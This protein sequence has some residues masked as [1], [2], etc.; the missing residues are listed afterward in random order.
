MNQLITLRCG[1]RSELSGLALLRESMKLSARAMLHRRQTGRWLEL[2]NSHPLFRQMLPACPRLVNK[3]YRSYF[4]TRLGCDDRLA[5]LQAHYQTVIQRG[6]APLVARAAE[7]PVEL[8]RLD[9]KTGQEY[10]IELRAG[11]VLCREGELILQLAHGDQV[12]YSIAF[13]FLHHFGAVAVGVGCLQGKH[14]GGGLDQ[15][16]D[17]T[18]EL[19][20]MRPKNLLVRLVRQ[21]GHDHG[22]AQ[23]ILVGNANRVVTTSMKQGKVH[24]D[25]DALWLELDAARQPDGDFSLA[26]EHLPE[27]DMAQIASKKRSEARKRHEMLANAIAAMRAQVVRSQRAATPL[28]LVSIRATAPS[29]VSAPLL[30]L[31]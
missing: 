27:P 11:G 30:Q 7:G 8:C 10:R 19:H 28:R 31:G 26:C 25:Y 20:G 1:L 18:R 24:A 29:G 23:M 14:G 12:L 5:V 4:S 15:V 17:A 3:I 6:L 2:L 9:G 21:F 22:C 16:R 13:S